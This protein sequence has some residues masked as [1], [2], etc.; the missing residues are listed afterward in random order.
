MLRQLVF[1]FTLCFPFLSCVSWS[2][3]KNWYLLDSHNNIPVLYPPS[4][5]PGAWFNI[6]MPSYQY[7]KSHCGD[8]TVVDHLISTMGIPIPVRQHIYIESAPRGPAPFINSQYHGCWWPGNMRSQ[9]MSSL[10]IDL[11]ICIHLNLTLLCC[12]WIGY[13]SSDFKCHISNFLVT[14]TLIFASSLLR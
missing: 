7:R 11:V 12:T 9:D 14:C 3:H 1:L 6:K 5:W 2:F 8:K 13:I 10:G 4:L